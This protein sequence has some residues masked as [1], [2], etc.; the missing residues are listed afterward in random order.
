MITDCYEFPVVVVSAVNRAYPDP[1]CNQLRYPAPDCL[2]SKV[3]VRV[4]VID[5]QNGSLNCYGA[6]PTSVYEDVESN[7]R[8]QTSLFFPKH[9]MN[10][11]FSSETSF[12]GLPEDKTFILNGP[13]LDCSLLRNHMAHWLFRATGRYSP[14]TRHVAMYQRE[15]PGQKDARYVGIYLLLEKLSYGPNRVNLA[16]LDTT[17]IM[18]VSDLTGGWAWQNDPL[19]YGVYSPNVVVDQYQNEFG[20][21]ERPLLAYPDG[22]ALSQNIRDYFVNTTTG[23]LPHL[24]RFL[25]HNMTNPDALEQHLD[26][27]SFADYILHTEMSL[28]VDAYRRST[29]FFKDRAQTINAG[30]VWDLNLAYGNGARHSYKDWIFPQYTYWK[31]LM[32]NYKLTSLVI[33]RWKQLRD[34]ATGGAWSDEAITQFLDASAA[35]VNRQLQKCK[36]D[37]SSDARQC[38][39]VSQKDCNGT[40]VERVELLKRAV[41]DRSK[42]MDAHITELYKSLNATKCSGVG[43]IPKYN[44]A[45]NGDD[46]GCLSDPEKYYSAV[47]FPPIRKPYTGP[48]CAAKLAAANN[49]AVYT[50]QGT[51]PP[52]DQP[53]EDYCWKSA[54][55]YVYPQQ[56]GVRERNLTHFCSGYGTCPQG[57]GA[58]CKCRKG[59]RLEPTSCRRI[60]ADSEK[61][62]PAKTMKAKTRVKAAADTVDADA[63]AAA[64]GESSTSM[65]TDHKIFTVTV[66]AFVVVSAFF[67]AH[68]VKERARRDRL[69]VYRP[70]RYGSMEDAQAFASPR[71]GAEHR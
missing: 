23:F 3:G 34:N 41:L 55:L 52:E 66:A 42:W 35:P 31:R 10:I 51:V 39:F 25:W 33:Q 64:K 26:L 20:M 45:P 38:A 48:S 29:F 59:I 44:C 13:Y 7:Y 68:K 6:T 21:G 40:Y 32:C 37:W 60:D 57:P 67:V 16:K 15:S 65:W 28:N 17:C 30:P 69:N 62:M 58:K 46:D 22:G 27:G 47:T 49:A 19:S 18:D 5:H 50:V 63:N 4:E 14:R 2:K 56:K 12:I 70:V 61:F 11:K 54:G 36:S 1:T 71:H 53:S 43:E 9:Q 8:G 24:Y